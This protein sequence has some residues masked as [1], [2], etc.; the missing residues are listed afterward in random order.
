MRNLLWS[1]L[2]VFCLGSLMP[3]QSNCSGIA[4]GIGA[5]L[6]G[7]IPFPADSLWNQNISSAPVDPNSDAYINFLGSSTPLHPDFGSGL[8]GGQS[9]GIP[10]IVES[11][12]T[13]VKINFT[14][15]GDESDP[16]LMPIPANAPI[17]G[18]RGPATVTGT[19]SCSTATTAGSMNFTIL[20]CSKAELGMPARRRCGIC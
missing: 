18:I 8:Y 14:A 16:G 1:L 17:E 5:S 19:C 11:G 6:N 15:Y 2:L 12:T 4:L 10:Y 7:F 13:P 9:I 3:A 20:T